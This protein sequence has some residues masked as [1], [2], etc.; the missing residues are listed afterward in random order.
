MMCDRC[1][2]AK[3]TVQQIEITGDQVDHQ[4]LC[5]SCANDQ[6]T[7]DTV[8]DDSISNIVSS[9][10][11]STQDSETCDDCGMSFEEFEQSGTMGCAQC[12]ET[13]RSRL[14]SLV[15]RVHG[16]D[17]HMGRETEAGGLAKIEGERKLQILEKQ[18]NRAVNEEDYEKAA[19]LRDQ[20]EQHEEG[21]ND[22]SDH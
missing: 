20:I 21:S 9:M 13:F 12:Y 22:E 18:L 17:R 19:E 4:Q 2:E 3:A 16:S 1:G 6:S 14:E 10:F 7:E 15:H 5:E 8:P 11:D